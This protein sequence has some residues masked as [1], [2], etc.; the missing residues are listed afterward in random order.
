MFVYKKDKSKKYTKKKIIL[1]LKVIQSWREGCQ[2]NWRRICQCVDR[3]VW[4]RREVQLGQGLSK[5]IILLYHFTITYY[6]PYSIRHIIQH[7]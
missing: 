4:C 6:L 2:Q 3:E 7:R 5:R 1:P